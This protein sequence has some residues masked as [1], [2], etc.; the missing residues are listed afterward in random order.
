MTIFLLYFYLF[1]APFVH[2]SQKLC[3]LDKA[4][5]KTAAVW[6]GYQTAKIFSKFKAGHYFFL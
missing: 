3:A 4:A 1:P 5:S 6:P 2:A